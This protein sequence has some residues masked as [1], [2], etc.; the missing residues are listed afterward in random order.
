MMGLPDLKMPEDPLYL[1]LF[2]T[3]VTA[4][5]TAYWFAYRDLLQN[6]AIVQTG[7]VDNLLVTAVI[8]YLAVTSVV[9]SWF[10]NFSGSLTALFLLSF[11]FLLLKPFQE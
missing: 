8:I 3:A 4:F 11:V 7:I 9:E 10:I 2:G 1:R 6:R 5:A